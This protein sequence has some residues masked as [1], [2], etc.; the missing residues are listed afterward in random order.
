MS[1]AYSFVPVFR[2][3]KRI[4]CSKILT[5][6]I[7]SVLELGQRTSRF[8]VRFV[9]LYYFNFRSEQI[10]HF[11]VLRSRIRRAF[12][13]IYTAAHV[14]SIIYA[15][16]PFRLYFSNF[17]TRKV[18]PFKNFKPSK[19]NEQS[20]RFVANCVTSMPSERMDGVKPLTL[21]DSFYL[22]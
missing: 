2:T 19:I 4:V 22:F 8:S 13:N 1:I 3:S 10:C 9:S 16:Y 17:V 7:T 18:C 21:Y 11:K 6:M 15:T 20:D 5:D 12:R 14:C